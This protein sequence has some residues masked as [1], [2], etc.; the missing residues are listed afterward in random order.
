MFQEAS[1]LHSNHNIIHSMAAVLLFKTGHFIHSG[2][3]RVHTPDQTLHG[4]DITNYTL[5]SHVIQLN[6][7]H[8]TFDNILILH[9][10]Q[11]IIIT[12]CTSAQ[13]AGTHTLKHRIE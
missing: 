9:K 1:Q 13:L 6:S 8:K 12:F 11:L 7:E 10:L 3:L 2:Q 5:F 4:K